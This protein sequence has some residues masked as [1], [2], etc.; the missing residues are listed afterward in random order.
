MLSWPSSSFSENAPSRQV[1]AVTGC[2]ERVCTQSQRWRRA[3][4]RT[5]PVC[6]SFLCGQVS[7]FYPKTWPCSEEEVPKC[8]RILP[9]ETCRSWAQ[10]LSLSRG[11][12]SS[13]Q[14]SKANALLEDPQS[15]R[16]QEMTQLWR[17]YQT[18]RSPFRCLKIQ[19]RHRY[20]GWVILR[21][22]KCRH[23][24]VVRNETNVLPCS[25]K[26]RNPS[27]WP[28]H[29]RVYF[30]QYPSPPHQTP[31]GGRGECACFHD[32]ACSN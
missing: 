14:T 9:I 25:K 8:E 20:G 28:P 18:L 22:K 4:R 3:T 29:D 11:G 32:F 12:N 24:K 15:E 31:C 19:M 10:L 7:L 2:E 26:K 1:Q 16:K 30:P 17:T 13:P 21:C 23:R 6:F 5:S 27:T